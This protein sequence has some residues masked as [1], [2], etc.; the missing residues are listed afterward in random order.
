MGLYAGLMSGTSMDAVD[1][2]L[3]EVDDVGIRVLHHQQ[4]PVPQAL[5]ARLERALV[6]PELPALE[7][8]R[9][10]AQVGALFAAAAA[11][12]LR[13]AEVDAGRVRAIGSH[14]QTLYHAVDDTPAL[15]VQVGD[16]NV[17][18]AHTGIATVADFRRMDV[19]L[20]G[21]GAPLAPLF[22]AFAF[23]G[24][25]PRAVLNLGGIANV[26]LLPAAGEDGVTG[27][28]TGPA[29]VLLDH[30]AREHLGRAFDDDGAWAA[31][32]RLDAALLERML[33]EPYFGRAP[34]KS[35]GRERFNRRWLQAMLDGLSPAPADVQRTLVELV[36]VS[37]ARSLPRRGT[38]ALYLCGGGARNG[39]LVQ[40]LEACLPGWRVE[41][42]AA[43]GVPPES[44][45]GAAFA[46]LARERLHGRAAGRPS[47][48]GAAR[49]AHL[50]AVYLP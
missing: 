13:A 3:A 48:T 46:W 47:V 7:A 38:H 6:T 27:F 1:A 24:A 5:R 26:T 39:F 10:D 22:H 20:G 45:E 19:A 15:T 28:D 9:L 11:G 16:P 36:A 33:A 14:G 34:P 4:T 32:G 40:R 31:S 12:L 50:G 37:V 2:V 49:A 42:T 18:A 44:V 8:W 23:C 35:T 17:I 41:S 43:L 30:M 25:Q 29:N 21:Q